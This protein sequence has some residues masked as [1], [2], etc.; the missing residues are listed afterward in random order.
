MAHVQRIENLSRHLTT[1]TGLDMVSV[2]DD[3]ADNSV[4]VGTFSPRE[5]YEYTV[6]DNIELR[7][8]ILDFLKVNKTSPSHLQALQV[9]LKHCTQQKQQESVCNCHYTRSLSFLILQDD[10][11]K[12]NHYLAL[13]DF[14]QQTLERFQKFVAQRFFVTKDYIDGK[15]L[16]CSCYPCCKTPHKHKS[17]L[18][19]VLTL[20]MAHQCN[21]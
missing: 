8:R 18:L 13:M 12:P 15:N 4:T 17:A 2:A 7:D 1:A 10:I 21:A 19:G 9:P 5:L 14:R 3:L 11:F 20:H 16:A 6:R